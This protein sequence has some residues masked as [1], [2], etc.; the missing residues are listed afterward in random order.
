MENSE[1]NIL[2][3]LFIKLLK[4]PSFFKGVIIYY[5]TNSYFL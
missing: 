1:Y 2:F 3:E 4:Y 5:S